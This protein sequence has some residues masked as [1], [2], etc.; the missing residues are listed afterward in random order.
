MRTF[1]VLSVFVLT[2]LCGL[3]VSDS[4]DGSS[5]I[6]NFVHRECVPNKEQF[7]GDFEI[8]D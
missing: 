7:S 4:F 8:V 1:L 2:M 3:A 6:E 5:E